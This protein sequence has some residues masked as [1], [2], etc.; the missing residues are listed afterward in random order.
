MER[1]RGAGINPSA[2]KDDGQALDFVLQS[3]HNVPQLEEMARYGQFYLQHANDF[4]AYLQQKQQP[5]PQ[6]P[7]APKPKWQ[8]KEY[9]RGW[10]HLLKKDEHGGIVPIST[11][12]DP[13]LPQKYLEYHDWQDEQLFKML[14]DPRAF[15]KPLIEEDLAE[16]E[17]KAYQRAMQDFQQAL[18]VEQ[19]RQQ[20]SQLLQEHNAWLYQR[21]G[22][23]R[24]LVDVRGYP[25]LSEAGRK[26]ASAVNF[27]AQSGVTDT[28]K[29][30]QIG[31][32]AVGP[33]MQS[34]GHAQPQGDPNQSRRDRFANAGYAPQANGTTL[35]QALDPHH[36]Q[37]ER[38]SFLQLAE[39]TM[40]QRG[41][42]HLIPI[43][44]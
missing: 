13:T 36:A 31:L 7:E 37:N 24:T 40:R 21:D 27:A 6:A 1:L 15:F 3:I 39:Q 33:Q 38:L 34:N 2:F 32:L 18:Q 43:R 9:D 11:G 19:Q 44:N 14:Q 28:G 8:A 17:T 10:K 25:V 22:Q 29:Q 30:H 20:T 5:A 4:Q 42:E 35:N 41:Q 12:I 16:V 26:Y 23:G